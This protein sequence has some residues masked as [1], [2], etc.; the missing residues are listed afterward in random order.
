[1]KPTSCKEKRVLC[2]APAWNEGKRIASVV[3]AV[4]SEVVTE[5]LVIDDGSNDDTSECAKAAGALVISNEV[6][7]GVG[8]AIRRGI[9]FAIKQNY[10]IIVVISGAGKTPPEQI[11]R[12][13]DPV[14]EGKAE[15][16]QG[17]RYLAEGEFIRAPFHRRIGTSLYTFLF[18]LFS[19]KK[20]TDASSGFRAFKV[21]IFKN[22]QI[23]LWQPWLDCYELEPYLLFKVLKLNYR[24]IEVPVTIKYPPKNDK[25]G[26]TKMRMLIDWWKIFRPV[27]FLAIGFKK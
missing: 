25:Q 9:D 15:F 18:S 22:N 17:S 14:I 11:P 23:N 24:I 21:S 2:I 6:N 12:L 7:R 5:I 16:V 27:L 13:V 10:D 1:M 3:K 26:Y 4:P 20:I 8:A 19:G